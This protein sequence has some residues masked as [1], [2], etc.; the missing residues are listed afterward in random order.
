MISVGNKIACNKTMHQS[1]H[2]VLDGADG[3]KMPAMTDSMFWSI[4]CMWE[5]GA[6]DPEKSKGQ[7]K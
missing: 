6:H 7:I 4:N 2:R 1:K 5:V 3:I